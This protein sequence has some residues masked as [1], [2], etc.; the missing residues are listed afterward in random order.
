MLELKI[1]QAGEKVILTLDELKTLDNPYYLFVFK[2]VETKQ[3]VNFI[4][5][6]ADDESQYQVRYNQ[7]NVDSSTVFL[8]KATGEWR[9]SVYEQPGAVNTD[10]ALA[11]S[12]LEKGKMMLLPAGEFEMEMY[13]QSTS[14]KAYNG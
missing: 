11:T 5:S 13:N 6:Q 1:D 7:F 3:V 2:H 14:F 9:Y 10:P 8:G 12:L 4:R